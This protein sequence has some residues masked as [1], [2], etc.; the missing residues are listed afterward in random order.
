MVRGGEIF[1]TEYWSDVG[2][3]VR[4]MICIIETVH[5]VGSAYVLV[6]HGLTVLLFVMDRDESENSADLE[7]AVYCYLTTGH[8]P[9]TFLRE[10]GNE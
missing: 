2:E 8:T 1:F 5:V 7:Q 9:T 3:L 4:P 10:T 6:L